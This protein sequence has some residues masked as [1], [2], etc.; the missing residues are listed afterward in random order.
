LPEAGEEAG[1][2]EVLGYFNQDK[3]EEDK[4]GIL[5]YF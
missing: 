5:K 3:A 4:G 2:K 1:N